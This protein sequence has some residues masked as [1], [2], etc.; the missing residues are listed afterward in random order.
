MEIRIPSKEDLKK[1]WTKLKG[2]AVVLTLLGLIQE[3]LRVLASL[4]DW[5]SRVEEALSTAHQIEPIF[6]LLFRFVASPWFGISLILTGVFYAVFV[7]VEQQ[8]RSIK[9]ATAVAW[10]ACVLSGLALWSLILISVGAAPPRRLA[11]KPGNCLLRGVWKHE[12]E[13]IR[14]SCAEANG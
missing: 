6:G 1:L 2:P 5:K 9:V 14:I 10:G 11:A 13:Q 8:V 3:V 7:P 12:R 4:L